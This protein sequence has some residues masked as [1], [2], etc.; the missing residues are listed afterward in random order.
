MA[1]GSVGSRLLN[2]HCG[3]VWVELLS[4]DACS[5]VTESDEGEYVCRVANEGGATDASIWL[6]VHC[7]QHSTGWRK[8]HS[9]LNLKTFLIFHTVVWRHCKVVDERLYYKFTLS[10]DDFFLKI[11]QHLA[12]LLTRFWLTARFCAILFMICYSKTWS[13]SSLFSLSLRYVDGQRMLLT[14]LCI[15]IVT[16]VQVKCRS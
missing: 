11:S 10:E 12:K 3:D 13:L 14:M 16:Y 7:K 4:M 1:Y 5:N 15:R 9:H 6:F 2:F 8:K